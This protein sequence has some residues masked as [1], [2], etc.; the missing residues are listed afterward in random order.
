MNKEKDLTKIKIDILH[1]IFGS[2]FDEYAYYQNGIDRL[3]SGKEVE[4][5]T[6]YHLGL[7]EE[8][9]YPGE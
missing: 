6:H 4:V 1:G 5:N 8:D 2:Y 3:V 7:H 9:I